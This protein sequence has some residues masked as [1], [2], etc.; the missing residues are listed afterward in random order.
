MP[1]LAAAVW[2]IGLVVGLLALL[3]GDAGVA[4]VVLV[5]AVVTPWIGIARIS[6][7]DAKPTDF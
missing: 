5:V 1:G 7:S 4:L 6:C 3:A 2:T